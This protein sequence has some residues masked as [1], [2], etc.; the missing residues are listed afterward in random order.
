LSWL[1]HSEGLGGIKL[2]V[3]H[4]VEHIR[5]CVELM[6]EEFGFSHEVYC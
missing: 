4:T 1:S 6:Y 3:S 5:N 2:P